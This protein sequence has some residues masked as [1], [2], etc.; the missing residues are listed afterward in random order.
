M[1]AVNK[2]SYW[3]TFICLCFSFYIYIKILCWLHRNVQSQNGNV[4]LII[5][6]VKPD[7]SSV[8]ITQ[9]S[10]I[11]YYTDTT[12]TTVWNWVWVVSG[13]NVNIQS[14]TLLNT[15]LEPHVSTV[16]K[17]LREMQ[18]GE[19]D[20]NKCPE[21][22]AAVT[23]VDWNQSGQWKWWGAVIW[24]YDHWRL[25]LSHVS[26]IL[27]ASFKCSTLTSFTVVVKVFSYFL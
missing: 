22:H 8:L 23:V 11:K 6:P 10:I 13:C 1:N 9:W 4:K 16:T 20:L 17:A 12:A 27:S 21:L 3:H 14:L 26:D 15:K 19:K 2:N 18:G 25:R 5:W 24:L 7:K